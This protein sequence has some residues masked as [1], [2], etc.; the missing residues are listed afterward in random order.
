MSFDWSC[1]RPIVS[2]RNGMLRGPDRKSF[3]GR[4]AMRTESGL[5]ILVEVAPGEHYNDW[6]PSP[7]VLRCGTKFA[8]RV[9]CPESLSGHFYVACPSEQ[10]LVPVWGNLEPRSLAARHDGSSTK[11]GF[12]TCRGLLVQTAPQDCDRVF[13]S[14]VRQRTCA[15]VYERTKCCRPE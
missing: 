10:L 9:P 12:S 14:G 6:K 3:P 13:V 1:E 4:Y 11:A 7:P 8:R 2:T 15:F 5:T